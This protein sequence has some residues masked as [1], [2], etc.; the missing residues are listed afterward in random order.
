V[1]TLWFIGLDVNKQMSR[2]IDLTQE[3]QQF[4]DTV[5]NTASSA[6]N[7][8]SYKS[9]MFIRPSYVRHKDLGAWL[10]KEDLNRGRSYKEKTKQDRSLNTSTASSTNGSSGGKDGGVGKESSNTSQLEQ[11]II[12]TEPSVVAPVSELPV[13]GTSTIPSPLH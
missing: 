1:Y 10:S 12:A 2:N 4:N 11:A 13:S 9:T 8:S 5:V 3:L 6:V 7:K